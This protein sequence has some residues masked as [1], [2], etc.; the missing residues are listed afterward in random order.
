[1]S[2][3]GGRERNHGGCDRRSVRNQSDGCDRLRPARPVSCKTGCP[4]LGKHT[5]LASYVFLF[6]FVVLRRAGRSCTSNDTTRLCNIATKSGSQ[7]VQN[8]RARKAPA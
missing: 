6:G 7:G 1:C 5:R 8:S 2:T 4:T 3:G